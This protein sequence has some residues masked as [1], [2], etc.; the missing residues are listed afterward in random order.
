MTALSMGFMSLITAALLVPSATVLEGALYLM[1]F[2]GVSIS[3]GWL[4]LAMYPQG[5]RLTF[6]GRYS[7]YL[8]PAVSF[9]LLV[10]LSIPGL[11]RLFS[12]F[13]GFHEASGYV[14]VT[15]AVALALV[16]LWKMA[17]GITSF[18]GKNTVGC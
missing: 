14:A 4:L 1:A 5:R 13:F 12:G 17:R 7:R 18:S 16:L 10:A 6:A 3:S 8:I 11:V 15:F 2:N 9:L